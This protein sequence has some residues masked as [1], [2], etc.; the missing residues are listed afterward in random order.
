MTPAQAALRQIFFSDDRGARAKADAEAAL[1]ALQKGGQASGDPL[2]LPLSYAD[3]SLDGLAKDF[4]DDF[5]ADTGFIPQV[6]YREANADGGWTW[7]PHGF[8]S[9]VRPG[10][11]V[12]TTSGPFLPF[13]T[14]KV[15]R[16]IPEPCQAK[17][18]SS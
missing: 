15:S 18:S 16:S 12:N 8:V 3:V 17:I 14:S 6:G 4:G 9:R 2:V 11:W 13:R 1:A 7:R 10:V 5:R